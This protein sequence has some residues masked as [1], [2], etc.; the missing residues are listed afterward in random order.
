MDE[1]PN[2]I[3]TCTKIAYQGSPLVW[4]E[5]DP[6]LLE[7][8]S[9]DRTTALSLNQEMLGDLD[10]RG[11]GWSLKGDDRFRDIVRVY[12]NPPRPSSYRRSPPPLRGS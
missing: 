6:N 9:E 11:P 3:A 2:L 7:S 1:F 10:L 12:G 5:T 4:V 8:P